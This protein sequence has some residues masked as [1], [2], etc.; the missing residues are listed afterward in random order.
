M[1]EPVS[2]TEN[3]PLPDEA[4]EPPRREPVFNLPPAVLAVIGICV[5]V[6]LVRVY[7]LTDDQDFALLVRAAFVPIRYSGRYDLDFYAFSSP[8][9]YAFLHGGVAHLLINMIWLAAFG[10][11]LANRFGTLRFALFF[12]ATSLASVVLFWALHPLGEMPLV[13]ASGAISGM[14]G[15]AARYGFRVD[16]SSGKAAF[17]GEPLPIAAVLRSRGVMTF[18]GV[19]MVINLATGLLGFAPGI[20]GQIA[21]EAHI[22]GFV[23]GFF[24]LRFFDRPPAAS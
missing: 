23:A 22:G 19:W 17:A 20:D 6:H 7:L 15:A 10:S 8:F 1:S 13:G 21:W 11:P 4:S 9:T 14:M 2:P 5:A 12:A 24:G 3:E 16:R 18:L